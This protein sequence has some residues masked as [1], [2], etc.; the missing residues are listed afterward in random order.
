MIARIAGRLVEKELDHVVVDVGGV[1][2]LV[3]VSA[4]TFYSL[5]EP[6]AEV[7]LFVRTIVRDDDIALYG[8]LVPLEKVLFARL[9][10]VSG[11][12]PK[13]AMNLLAA[14][15]APELL[16][17]IAAGD[18]RALA[19][20]PGIGKKTAERLIVDLAEK[21]AKI[22]QEAKLDAPT[23]PPRLATADQD[24]VSALV[25]LG[26]KEPTAVDSVAEARRQ[27]GDDATLE[28]VIRAALRRQAK[29]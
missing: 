5:P 1:G 18:A 6:P 8:F 3:Q 7:V 25:N 17:T 21:A 14:I 10:S 20:V 13:A 24:A 22:L 19:K 2:Y 12:G 27:V 15:A 9:I 11:V 16:A 26:F 29:G 23:P 28:D 4:N